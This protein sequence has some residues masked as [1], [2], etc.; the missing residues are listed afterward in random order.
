MKEFYIYTQNMTVGYGRQPLIEQIEIRLKRG[1]I[2][3]LDR[4]S[5]V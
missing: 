2:L 3:T 1:E 4:K 5:V